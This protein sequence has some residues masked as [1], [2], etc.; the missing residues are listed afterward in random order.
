MCEERR[1]AHQWPPSVRHGPGRWP[2]RPSLRCQPGTSARLSASPPHRPKPYG[3]GIRTVR[4]NPVPPQLIQADSTE[5][6]GPGLSSCPGWWCI[7][8]S[9]LRRHSKLRQHAEPAGLVS[10]GHGAQPRYNIT[11]T[12]V[13]DGVVPAAGHA[14]PDGAAATATTRALGF[15][16]VALVTTNDTD[17]T[18]AANAAV[19]GCPLIV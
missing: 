16:H 10:A 11:A 5:A 18:I 15:R 13:P 6:P 2:S 7:C 9:C 17:P 3:S 12:F 8:L 14:T 1:P 4:P 19:G